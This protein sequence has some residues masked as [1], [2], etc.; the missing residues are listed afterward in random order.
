MSLQTKPS[1]SG[2]SA[3]CSQTHQL[4][5][6]PLSQRHY[7]WTQPPT[8]TTEKLPIGG[9]REGLR[10]RIGVESGQR[11]DTAGLNSTGG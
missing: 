3:A 6:Q 7:C 11:G 10:D 5:I 8:T 9:P 2:F 1:L 4:L